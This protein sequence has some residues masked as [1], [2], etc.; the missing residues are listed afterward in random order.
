MITTK[1]GYWVVNGLP[2]DKKIEAVRYASQHN[3]YIHFYYHDNV[4]EAYLAT[5]DQTSFGKR[6]L[7]QLYKERAEQL[8][9]KYD[10]LVLYYSGGTDSHN[11]LRTFIDNDIKL[12]EVN[13]KWPKALREGKL[14]TPDPHDTS[15]FNFVSEW[16]YAIK[17]MLEHLKQNH[18]DVKITFSDYTEQLD[19]KAMENIIEESN[20]YRNG[21]ILYSYCYSDI[22][23]TKPNVGHIYGID[24]PLL[25][26][27]DKTIR[28]IFTDMP[29]TLFT[30]PSHDPDSLEF[31]YWSPDMP[32]LTVE[33]A[34]QMSNYFVE[35]PDTIKYLWAND[36]IEHYDLIRDFQHNIAIKTCYTTWNY[37]FQVVRPNLAVNGNDKWKW[38]AEHKEFSS[39]LDC[40]SENR[41]SMFAGVSDQYILKGGKHG[42]GMKTC[43]SQGYYLR[44]I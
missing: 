18:P 43:Y 29:T 36:N 13:I 44:D 21:A 37:R 8:R 3:A 41:K 17:P 10:Y 39:V 2:F 9:D 15:A 1:Y 19:N 42:D 32:A 26:R 7:T 5:M 28:M 33:M 23:L 38:F 24:K 27:V 6:S 30:P 16:D 20:H 40:L 14:Y 34:Y 4:W 22:C 31:F 35:N 11:I 12:D 25:I